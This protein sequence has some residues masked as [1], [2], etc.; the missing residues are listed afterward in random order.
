[1]LEPE[2]FLCS[3]LGKRLTAYI[4]HTVTKCESI[5]VLSDLLAS[6]CM[7]QQFAV[8]CENF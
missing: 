6:E 8:Y 4:A 5:V 2:T 1:M 7:C 3:T